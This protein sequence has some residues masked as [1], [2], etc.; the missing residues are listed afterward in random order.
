MSHFDDRTLNVGVQSEVGRHQVQS[1]QHG[2]ENLPG[3]EDVGELINQESQELVSQSLQ[4]D[5]LVRSLLGCDWLI[6]HPE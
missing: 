2:E 1:V 4:C 5:W 3:P 6:F